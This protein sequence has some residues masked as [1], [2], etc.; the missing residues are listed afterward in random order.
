MLVVKRTFIKS[1]VRMLETNLVFDW[2]VSS[3]LT[4]LLIKVLLTTS[5]SVAQYYF[6]TLIFLTF[7]FMKRD[8]TR[9]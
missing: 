8:L 6:N 5:I 7:Y 4:L 3:I 9:Y 1:K 2:F